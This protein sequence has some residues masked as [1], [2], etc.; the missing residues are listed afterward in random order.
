LG[1]DRRGH[2]PDGLPR[3]AGDRWP[4]HHW[5]KQPLQ[6]LGLAQGWAAQPLAAAEAQV[7]APPGLRLTAWGAHRRAGSRTVSNAG[8]EGCGLVDTRRRRWQRPHWRSALERPPLRVRRPSPPR[9]QGVV[10]EP[11]LPRVLGGWPWRSRSWPL[12]KSRD[13]PPKQR[14]VSCRIGIAVVA[15]GQQRRARLEAVRRPPPDLQRSP[16]D[17]FPAG[18]AARRCGKRRRSVGKAAASTTNPSSHPRGPL[19]WHRLE[20]QG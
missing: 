9:L 20:G 12:K 1:L 15:Q 14:V 4:T 16:A 3:I 5:R 17:S 7:G 2:R 6:L 13:R 10:P 8:P 19:R 18:A 11:L